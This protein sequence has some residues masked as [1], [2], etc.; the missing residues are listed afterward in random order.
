L[1]KGDTAFF[2]YIGHDALFPK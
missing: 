2:A 1:L